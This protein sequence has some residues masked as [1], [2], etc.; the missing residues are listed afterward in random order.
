MKTV[1][2]LQYCNYHWNEEVEKSY[3]MRIEDGIA[4][5]DLYSNWYK[6]LTPKQL[7]C[8]WAKGVKWVNG[9]MVGDKAYYEEIL[10]MPTIKEFYPCHQHNGM[11]YCLATLFEDKESNLD[12]WT[13]RLEGD[14]D[15]SISFDIIGKEQAYSEWNRLLSADC[16]S[17]ELVSEYYF[18]N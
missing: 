12:L 11:S 6:T 4:A 5:D 13:V 8:H 14:D 15:Y 2:P 18:S 3:A 9:E 10:Y 17:D 1:T 7:Y 16:I